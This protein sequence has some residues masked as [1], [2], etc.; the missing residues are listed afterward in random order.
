MAKPNSATVS[1]AIARQCAV[2]SL[3]ALAAR[4]GGKLEAEL[5]Q[6]KAHAEHLRRDK[7]SVQHSIELLREI[8]NQLPIGVTVQEQSG[9]FVLVNTMAAAN[10]ATPADV[11]IGA[12][13]ADFLPAN[14]AAQRRQWEIELIQS[15]KSVNTEENIKDA[16]GE[17]T[18]LTSHK[19]VRVFEK[20]VPVALEFA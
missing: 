20:K 8:T 16:T 2:V 11:L 10:L 15:D 18:W 12:S 14:E 13:P 6:V 9:R 17:R 1:V 4:N 19:P 3:A 7:Q 5:L